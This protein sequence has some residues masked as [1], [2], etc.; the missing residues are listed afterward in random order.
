MPLHNTRDAFHQDASPA[1]KILRLVCAICGLAISLTSLVGIL[2]GT[3]FVLMGVAMT[4][5][6]MMPLH[7]VLQRRLR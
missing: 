4:C 3:P 7:R 1:Q 5:V 6:A 2:P